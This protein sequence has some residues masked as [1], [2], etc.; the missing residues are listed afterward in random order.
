MRKRSKSSARTSFRKILRGSMVRVLSPDQIVSFHDKDAESSRG[1]KEGDGNVAMDVFEEED[2]WLEMC[3][4]AAINVTLR[5]VAGLDNTDSDGWAE[6]E[7]VKGE[8][9]SKPAE[10]D[11][12]KTGKD[13][14]SKET[15]ESEIKQVFLQAI[16]YLRFKKP[17]SLAMTP[18]LM[19]PSSSRFLFF[20]SFLSFL[21][22][23]RYKKKL[24][25][26]PAQPPLGR[27]ASAFGEPA[28]CG[29]SA[30][31]ASSTLETRLGARY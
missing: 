9:K 17:L 16:Y 19:R 8:E 26:R 23:C 7:E 2:A 29:A 1:G 27:V 13:D 30:I 31:T 25:F 24:S 21:S 11:E 12:T 5:S 22:C 14:T 18:F 3:P 10:R 20:A 4:W 6:L 28:W 15:K